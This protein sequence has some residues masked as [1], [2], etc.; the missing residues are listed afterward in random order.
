MTSESAGMPMLLF[1]VYQVLAGRGCKGY[2]EPALVLGI[3]PLFWTMDR[4]G[5]IRQQAR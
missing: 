3:Y 1:L 5:Q 4:D 2:L